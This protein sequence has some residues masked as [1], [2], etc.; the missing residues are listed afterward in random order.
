MLQT[1]LKWSFG[2]QTPLSDRKDDLY[3]TPECATKALLACES[4][5]VGIWEP[6]CG[7]GAIASVLTVAGHK[8]CSSDLVD[9]GKGYAGVDFLMEYKMPQHCEAIVTNPPYKLAGQFVRHAINLCPKVYMMLPIYFIESQARSDVLD[10]GSLARIHV[11]KRRLPMMHR[12]G[13][14]GP[15]TSSAQSHG[16]FVWDRDHCGPTMLDRFAY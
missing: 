13:W 12:D 14:T 10:S 8:V 9:Y 11:F 15:K 1:N 7:R 6:A 5:P 16:W 4:L 3:E 2:P